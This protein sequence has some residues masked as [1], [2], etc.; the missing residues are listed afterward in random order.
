[1]NLMLIIQTR[2]KLLCTSLIVWFPMLVL[3][4]YPFLP[5]A[6]EVC[7]SMGGC[8]PH[9]MLGY[10][11]PHRHPQA[12]TPGQTPPLGRHPLPPQQTPPLGRHPPAQCMLGY[13]QQAGGTHPTGMQSCSIRYQS[14]QSIGASD[15][16][17]WVFCVRV[18]VELLDCKLVV[19]IKEQKF[20]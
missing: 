15:V 20:K 17:C 5:P 13:G 12:D 11:P 16:V 10:T 3:F 1:M 4:I 18:L 8:L 2:N 7:L 6:N 9:C 19:L 14:I